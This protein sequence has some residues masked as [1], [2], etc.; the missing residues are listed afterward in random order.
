M[1]TDSDI[2]FN[3]EAHSACVAM[4]K[5][6]MNIFLHC[7]GSST[8]ERT[9]LTEYQI[10]LVQESLILD[11][12]TSVLYYFT[13]T[14]SSIGLPTETS[15]KQLCNLSKDSKDLKCKLNVFFYFRI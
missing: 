8:N 5:K 9:T 10:F 4:A 1:S 2:T 11:Q 6:A 12:M 14:N 7:P 13:V 3:A 15:L